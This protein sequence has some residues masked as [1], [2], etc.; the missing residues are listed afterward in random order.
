M[1]KQLQPDAVALHVVLS[2]VLASVNFLLLWLVCSNGVS[3]SFIFSRLCWVL[4]PPSCQVRILPRSGAPASLA[5]QSLSVVEAI[6]K[7]QSVFGRDPDGRRL[8]AV[9]TQIPLI[10]QLWQQ[11][12]DGA[13]SVAIVAN[14][15]RVTHPGSCTAR[16]CVKRAD[17]P[18]RHGFLHCLLVHVC[19]RS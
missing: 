16:S 7:Q 12:A 1:P 5:S 13:R 9:I 2:S 18:S 17:K 10:G 3:H 4:S 11:T 6:P 19:L 8:H 14:N 15:T